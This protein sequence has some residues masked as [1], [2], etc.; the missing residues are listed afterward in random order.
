M[1]IKALIVDDEDLARERIHDLLSRE[2]DFQVIGECANGVQAVEAIER[3][4]PDL[5]FLDIQMPLLDGF[6]VVEAVGASE[7]PAT[8]FVQPMTSMPFRLSRCMPWITC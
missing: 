1:L 7:M 4:Q 6:G 8:M 3:L 5:V 2:P